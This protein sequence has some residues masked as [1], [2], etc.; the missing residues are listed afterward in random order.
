MLPQNA[1]SRCPLLPALGKAL[2]VF[3]TA[4]AIVVTLVILSEGVPREQQLASDSMLGV[5]WGG[6][7][8]RGGR[9]P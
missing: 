2:E 6:E 7:R 3:Q 8:Q 9:H 5:E 1:T 4:P